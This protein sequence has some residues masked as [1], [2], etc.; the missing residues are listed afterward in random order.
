MLWSIYASHLNNQAMKLDDLI[1]P[2][3]LT[4]SLNEGHREYNTS[5]RRQWPHLL[6]SGPSFPM[7]M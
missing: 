4:S 5:E 7:G 6:V 2:E 1:T 3:F